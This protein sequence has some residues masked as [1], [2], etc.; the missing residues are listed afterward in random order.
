MLNKALKGSDRSAKRGEN[1]LKWLTIPIKR[2]TSDTLV[3][4]AMESIA[5]TLSGSG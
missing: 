1:L 5:A 3:G 2:L 4:S